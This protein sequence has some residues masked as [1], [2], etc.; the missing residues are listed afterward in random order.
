MEAS[1]KA[2]ITARV[3]PTMATMPGKVCISRDAVINASEFGHKKKNVQKE[4][5]EGVMS[6]YS[7]QKLGHRR[8]NTIRGCLTAVQA[9]ICQVTETIS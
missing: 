5:L 7:R 3:N 1:K 9:V 6:L 8:M 2:H 4:G